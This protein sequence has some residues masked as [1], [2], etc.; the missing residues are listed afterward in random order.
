MDSE[1][2]GAV[3]QQV[4]CRVCAQLVGAHLVGAQLV[5]AEFIDAKP[6][7]AR[8]FGLDRRADFGGRRSDH[9][10][11]TRVPEEHERLAADLVHG[12]AEPPG[13]QND[14][15]HRRGQIVH[16]LRRRRSGVVHASTVAPDRTNAPRSRGRR[17]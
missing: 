3:E 4:A 11:R 10:L 2:E 17:Y 16:V 5:G 8:A 6:F 15:G 9:D 12:I 7:S 1:V 13:R 14:V